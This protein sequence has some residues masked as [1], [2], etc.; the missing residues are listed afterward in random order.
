MDLGFSRRHQANR[1][2]FRQ[3]IELASLL[4][5]LATRQAL[6]PTARQVTAACQNSANMP[7]QKVKA[8]LFVPGKAVHSARHI[9]AGSFN[10]A[11]AS[12]LVTGEKQ[13]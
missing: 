4:A 9:G 6:S 10:P 5:S 2:A 7:A 13:K 3:D 1:P 11:A 12:L 8:D